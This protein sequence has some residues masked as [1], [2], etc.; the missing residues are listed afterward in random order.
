MPLILAG[1]VCVNEHGDKSAIMFLN[2]VSA[3][4]LCGR[5]R[6]QLLMCPP[7]FIQSDR[8]I[9]RGGVFRALALLSVRLRIG[10]TG[11]QSLSFF[12]RL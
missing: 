3:G 1:R 8:Y 6:M 12:D 7:G 9:L 5:L 4:E 2:C 10:E 11:M